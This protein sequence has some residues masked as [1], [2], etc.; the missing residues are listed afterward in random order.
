MQ[1]SHREITGPCMEHAIDSNSLAAIHAD[2]YILLVSL[3]CIID[4]HEAT[5][6]FCLIADQLQPSGNRQ[7]Y[8]PQL[9]KVWTSPLLKWSKLWLGTKEITI[10][11]EVELD[12]KICR[13]EGGGTQGKKNNMKMLLYERVSH[14]SHRLFT[15][16]VLSWF[17]LPDSIREQ[18]LVVTKSRFEGAEWASGGLN[19]AGVWIPASFIS[20]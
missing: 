8:S 16:A 9:G 10:W 6:L 1:G 19:L 20:P 17:Y 4:D 15:A 14:S 11:C 5:I 3:F 7:V 12:R 2:S 18:F 13:Q